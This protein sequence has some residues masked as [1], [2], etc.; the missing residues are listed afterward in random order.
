MANVSPKGT[1]NPLPIEP[2]PGESG[3][4]PPATTNETL[5]STATVPSESVRSELSNTDNESNKPSA[6]GPDPPK[7]AKKET[8]KTASAPGSPKSDRGKKQSPEYLR[9]KELRRKA[10]EMRMDKVRLS[11]WPTN[12]MVKTLEQKLGE[13]IRYECLGNSLCFMDAWSHFSYKTIPH[14]TGQG[15]FQL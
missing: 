12:D 6:A 5:S 9:E 14:S 1:P 4:G 11:L 15:Q 3:R 8:H 10:F 13:K 2:D 7:D